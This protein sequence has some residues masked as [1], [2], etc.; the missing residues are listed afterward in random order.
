MKNYS[1]FIKRFASQPRM[2]WAVGKRPCGGTGL[3]PPDR[4]NQCHT[5]VAFWIKWLAITLYLTNTPP[6]P[7]KTIKTAILLMPFSINRTMSALPY[8]P[9]IF[10]RSHCWSSQCS[11]I[12]TFA[13][14]PKVSVGRSCHWLYL[15]VFH[16]VA[17]SCTIID[18]SHY[19]SIVTPV[20]FS[21]YF[22][23]AFNIVTVSLSFV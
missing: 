11:V 10:S 18:R 16:Y 3:L 5:L 13:H 6:T 12:Y 15:F 2:Y 17:P 21:A 19:L 4:S 22:P 14:I 7:A 9:S 1:R 8:L 23:I 20:P